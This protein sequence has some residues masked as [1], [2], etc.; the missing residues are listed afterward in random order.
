MASS[1]RLV[2]QAA[3]KLAA[4]HGI[5]VIPEALWSVAACPPGAA[6]EIGLERLS[7]SGGWLQLHL[8]SEYW[9]LLVAPMA[10]RQHWGDEGSVLAAMQQ[11]ITV[12]TA[13]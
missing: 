6:E 10:E 13:N 7:P 3:T 11:P 5:V 4:G 12:R 8:K 2:T 9:P 1:D